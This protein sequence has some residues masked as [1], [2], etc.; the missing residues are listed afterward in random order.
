MGK[1]AEETLAA[2][3][4]LARDARAEFK[5]QLIST[6]E[7]LRPERLKQDAADTANHYVEEGKEVTIATVKAHPVVFGASFLGTLAFW[8]R[9]PLTHEVQERGPDAL[10]GVGDVLERLRDWIAPAGWTPRDDR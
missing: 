8:Y 7:R 3:K 6:R 10:D 9:K 1:R 4:T 5:S 2:A